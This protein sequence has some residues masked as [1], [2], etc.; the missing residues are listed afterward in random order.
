MLKK[1]LKEKRPR[2]TESSLNTYA[3][4]LR[5]VYKRAFGDAK[6]ED[7]DVSKFDKETKEV[8]KTLDDYAP[9]KRKS[10]LASLVVITGG[11]NAYR[12]PMLEDIQE[13]RSEIDKQ[14]KTQKQKEN[15]VTTEELEQMYAKWKT[16]ATPL[17]KKKEPLTSA[18]LQRVQNYVMLALYALIPPR[19]SAD[20]FNFKIRNVNESEDNFM[21]PTKVKKGQEEPTD[22]SGDPIK[23]KQMFVFNKYKTAWKYHAQNV[24]VPDEL[25]KVIKAW[26]RVNPH[27]YLL[28][29]VNGNKLDGSKMHARFNAIFGRKVSTTAFRHSFLTDK[30]KNTM[31]AMQEMDADLKKMGS[32]SAQASTYVKL[33]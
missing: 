16:I 10:I 1:I 20:Y 5:N 2:L 6:E 11:N 18:E 23:T 28:V 17:L 25:E 31:E 26:I 13:Y 9:S 32:S 14:Q 19:R 3:S 7:M 21:K 29:D 22:A 8:L 12:K 30:Y 4:V 27:E 33:D 15:W 24:G